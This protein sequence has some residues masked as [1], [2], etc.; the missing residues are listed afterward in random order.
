MQ[1]KSIR[2]EW[3]DGPRP[4]TTHS[5][6]HLKPFLKWAGGK[7]QLLPVLTH[8][9]PP[10]FH[11]YFEPFVGAG[12]LLLELQP[13]QAVLSD[14]NQELIS[15]YR[16]IQKHPEELIAQLQNHRNSSDY[17]YAIRG[18]DRHPEVFTQLDEIQQASRM[19]FLNK[20]CYNGL[21]RVNRK[22]EFNA[23]FGRYRNPG[24][25]DEAG[26]RS[27]HRFLNARPVRILNADFELAVA[28]ARAGD[29][30]YFDPPYDPISG[31]ASFTA[32]QGGGF[33][34]NEQ[35]R[36][37]RVVHD[38]TRRGCRVMLSNSATD[39]IRSLY[40]DLHVQ[41]VAATRRI[42]SVGTRRGEID[43]LLVLNYQPETGRM[44]DL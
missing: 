3:S 37:A 35:R 28:G 29:F 21:Y 32:Y 31:S 40:K 2:Q 15:C 36:L 24:I 10:G 41:R 30:V 27:I 13:R 7:R 12:A 6:S 22:G 43:E 8:L 16:V 26:I 33:G 23:P 5:D 42:N 4:A 39:F 38:L 34:H 1:A 14:L 9:M 20:T 11:T 18:L 17:F 25:V 19:I 44:I